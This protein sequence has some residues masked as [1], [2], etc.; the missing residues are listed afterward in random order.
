MTE[1]RI[2]D[3]VFQPEGTRMAFTCTLKANHTGEHRNITGQVLNASWRGIVYPEVG[4]P[5]SLMTQ[6]SGTKPMT[7]C[8][9]CGF[10]ITRCPQCDYATIF[11]P[12]HAPRGSG[13]HYAKR[14]GRLTRTHKLALEIL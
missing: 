11:F 3:S 13:A 10:Q 5:P 14:M 2:C 9:S 8:P 12:R 1:I 7:S 4:G 6:N